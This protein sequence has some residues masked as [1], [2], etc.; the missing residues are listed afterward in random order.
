MRRSRQ[1]GNQIQET[2][3]AKEKGPLNVTVVEAL[4]IV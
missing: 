1:T 4:L 3:P 2:E